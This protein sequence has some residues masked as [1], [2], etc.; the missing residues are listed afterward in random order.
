M[1]FRVLSIDGGGMRG[2]YTGTYLEALEHAFALKRNAPKGL[3]VGK[4]FQLIV[5][6]ST[7]AI[8]GC[9]LAKACSSAS[10]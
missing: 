9:G 10:R 2:I 3:D 4:A 6:T 5:G 1:A 7:G 8:L